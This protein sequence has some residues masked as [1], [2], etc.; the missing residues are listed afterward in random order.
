[1]LNLTQ[2]TKILLAFPTSNKKDYCLDAFVKQLQDITYPCDI[3]CIDNSPDPKHAEKLKDKFTGITKHYEIIHYYDKSLKI[4]ELI[5]DC[6][7]IIREKVINDNYGYWFS[8]ES[9]IFVK[10]NV[11]ELLL[12]HKKKVIGIAYFLGE[13]Y[14]S[15]FIH[16]KQGDLGR[17]RL[18][19]PMDS[20][21]GFEFVNGQAKYFYQLGLGCLLVHNIVLRAIKFR[22]SV[23]DEKHKRFDDTDF[24]D[25][26]KSLGIS[27]YAD[28]LYMATHINKNWNKITW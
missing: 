2:T 20:N 11:I 25:D 19:T 22:V 10:P 26:L 7:N 24:H 4:S 28:T 18:T 8:L 1:M 12:E 23:E 17:M 13:H 27:V 16:F 9:D 14:K 15:K 3:L 5:R 6:H 21:E